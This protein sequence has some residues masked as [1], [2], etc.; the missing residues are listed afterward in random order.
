MATVKKGPEQLAV[1]LVST[2]QTYLPGVL[3]DITAAWNDGLPLPAPSVYYPT[4]RVIYEEPTTLVVDVASWEVTVPA[5]NTA[6]G[7]WGEI[8]FDF[9]V[10]IVLR[11]EDAT[12]LLRR[13]HRYGQALWEVLMQHQGLDGV[14][15]VTGV[16]P[17]KG[18]RFTGMNEL[19][20]LQVM[21]G[22]MGTAMVDMTVG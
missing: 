15:P 11:G 20:Q 10:Y 6:G 8:A 5:A 7:G 18:R 13:A 19:Q 17:Q 2:M 22:W 21:E 12:S 16:N 9:E 1:A 4:L 14:I 3:T